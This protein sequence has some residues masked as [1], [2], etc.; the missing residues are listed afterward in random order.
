MFLGTSIYLSFNLM[1]IYLFV[2]CILVTLHYFCG[3]MFFKLIAVKCVAILNNI[4]VLGS[5]NI[6]NT[7]YYFIITNLKCKKNAFVCIL[8]SGKFG[9]VSSF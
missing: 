2:F 5:I 3:Q 9:T 8:I 1:T 7:Y 6:F 4:L